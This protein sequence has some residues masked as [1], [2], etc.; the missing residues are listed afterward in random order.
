ME[1]NF[2]RLRLQLFQE[3]SVYDSL[4]DNDMFPEFSNSFLLL[5]G[6]EEIRPEVVYSKFSNERDQQFALR[7]DICEPG[8]YERYVRKLPIVPKAEEHVK[9]LERIQRELN[10]IYEK[11]G[12]ELNNCRF[13][14]GRQSWN[15]WR[16]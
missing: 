6:R 1:T 9:N 15:I 13:E 7:T 2:D 5:I 10:T 14:Q 8:Q 12:I 4:L 11:E 3:S 16:E